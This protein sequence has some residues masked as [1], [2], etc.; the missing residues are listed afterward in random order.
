MLQRLASLFVVLVL[1]V[2]MDIAFA[3]SEP[4]APAPSIAVR[5][6]CV[7]GELVAV[8]VSTSRPGTWRI[9]L[10]GVCDGSESPTQ[11]SRM[12]PTI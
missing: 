6:Q 3:K 12:K 1:A 9:E 7:N 8:E 10:Q 11:E 2:L 4:A 5:G